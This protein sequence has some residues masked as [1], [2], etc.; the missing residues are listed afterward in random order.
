MEP[1]EFSKNLYDCIDSDINL[2]FIK[3]VTT[4]TLID[5]V[6]EAFKQAYL[7]TTLARLYLLPR[8]AMANNMW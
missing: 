6:V 8:Q 1:A 2:E 3:L 5:L 7:Q 4:L